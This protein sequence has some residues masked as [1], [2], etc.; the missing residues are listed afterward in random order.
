[1]N[2]D[3]YSS[4]KFRFYFILNKVKAIRYNCIYIIGANSNI[5]LYHYIKI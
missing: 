5:I 1:M 4:N 2:E 3:C